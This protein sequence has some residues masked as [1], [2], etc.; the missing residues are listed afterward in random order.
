LDIYW[1]D[2]VKARE[3]GPE[4]TYVRRPIEGERIDAQAIFLEQALKLKRLDVDSKPVLLKTTTMP[5]ESKHGGEK[6]SQPA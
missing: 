5:S 1:R 6:I 2:N 3:Q 4:P